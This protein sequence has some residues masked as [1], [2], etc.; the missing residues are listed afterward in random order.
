M[1]INELKK[2]HEK[3]SSNGFCEAY[4]PHFPAHQF[5]LHYFAPEYINWIAYF[6]TVSINIIWNTNNGRKKNSI[7]FTKPMKP[8]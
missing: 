8:N 4:K 1:R 6:W 7:I 2:F 3:G 5:A